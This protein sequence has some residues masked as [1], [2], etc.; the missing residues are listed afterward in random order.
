[1]VATCKSG[2]IRRKS[3]TTRRGTRVK[4]ACI[5]DLGK[6]GR[7]PK[8]IPPLKQGKLRAYGYSTSIGPTQRRAALMR[9]SRAYG[10]L[11][12]LRKLNAVKVLT[13]NSNPKASAVFAKDL[14]WIQTK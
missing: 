5:K 4:T 2:Q 6:T 7:G 11:S 12:V 14:A 1:M 8:V 13:R 10:K 3:Y 9:A